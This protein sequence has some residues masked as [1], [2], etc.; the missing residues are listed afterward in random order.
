LLKEKSWELARAQAKIEQLEGDLKKSGQQFLQLERAK[1]RETSCREECERRLSSVQVDNHRQ[2]S[3]SKDVLQ[4]AKEALTDAK[5]E[6]ERL[7]ELE[8]A[9]KN[10]CGQMQQLEQQHQSCGGAGCSKGQSVHASSEA[11]PSSLQTSPRVHGRVTCTTLGAT[12]QIGTSA[13]RALAKKKA[14]NKV[15]PVSIFTSTV[16]T[17]N[18]RGHVCGGRLVDCKYSQDYQRHQRE[19]LPTADSRRTPVATSMNPHE[20]VF[21]A[22]QKHQA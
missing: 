14:S 18:R 19:A 10:C 11:C 9:F 5:D 15:M 21:R 6:I 4:Q 12:P 16:T 1:Q 13:T 2:L 8:A 7:A 17:A 3:S 22:A 20:F